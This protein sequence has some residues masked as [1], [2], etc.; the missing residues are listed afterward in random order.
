MT[1]RENLFLLSDYKLAE[2]LITYHHSDTI[3][4]YLTSDDKIFEWEINNMPNMYNEAL[5]HE[6]E[7]LR[8]EL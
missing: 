1:N 8:R 6:I 3:N 2:R 7:W 5:Q 4:Y